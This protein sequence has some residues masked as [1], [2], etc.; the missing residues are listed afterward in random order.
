[1]EEFDKPT[2][3]IG[4]RIATL[5]ERR[6]LDQ[7]EFA[8]ISGKS[9]RTIQGWERDKVIPPRREVAKLGRTFGVDSG[10]LWTGEGTPPPWAGA[11]VDQDFRELLSFFRRA[12]ETNDDGGFD[13]LLTRLHANDPHPPAVPDEDQ[14]PGRD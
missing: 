11:D 3:G 12:V 1:M 6:G 5:R 10:W 14:G 13:A 7:A 4:G 9:L 8:A 2:T